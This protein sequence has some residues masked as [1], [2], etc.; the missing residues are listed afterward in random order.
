MDI[1]NK[2]K[3]NCAI[4]PIQGELYLRL[5]ANIYNRLADYEKLAQ[6]LVDILKNGRWRKFKYLNEF[7]EKKCVLLIDI[8]YKK[9]FSVLKV[10][11]ECI[12]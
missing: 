8:S 3:I 2:H 7:I 1:M 5:S 11:G 6:L 10:Y 4:Y 12:M 9:S